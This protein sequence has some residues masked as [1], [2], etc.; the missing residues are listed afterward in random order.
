MV[1]QSKD[2]P[3]EERFAAWEEI[4]ETMPDSSFTGYRHF[5]FKTKQMEPAPRYNSH[6]FLRRYI[7]RQKE[8]LDVFTKE[9]D[10][11]DRVFGWAA[12]STTGSIRTAGMG[13]MR[14]CWRT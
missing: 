6:D 12:K 4:I 13:A 1:W 14:T 2:T 9:G 7:Q 11:L 3:L 10:T 8:L 5:N